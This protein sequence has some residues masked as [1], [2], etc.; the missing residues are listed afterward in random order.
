[1]CLCWRRRWEFS[2]AYQA[3]LTTQDTRLISIEDTFE[4]V[5]DA[6]ERAEDAFERDKDSLDLTRQF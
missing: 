2:G 1:M 4:L 5:E 3:L 6:F